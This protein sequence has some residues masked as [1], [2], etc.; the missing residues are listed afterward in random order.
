MRA[1]LS[2]TQKDKYDSNH[3]R[4]PEE[5]NPKSWKTVH[6]GPERRL[7]GKF[8]F[9]GWKEDGGDNGYKPLLMSM[10]CNLQED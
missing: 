10:D 8:V 4:N 9:N 5:V 1:N 6:R 7:N 2:Q 3:V